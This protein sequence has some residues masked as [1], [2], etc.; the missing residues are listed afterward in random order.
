MRLYD[1]F[2]DKTSFLFL[3]NIITIKI[4][5]VKMTV[6]LLSCRHRKQRKKKIY[7]RLER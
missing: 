4:M 5:T 3:K 1:V 6:F 2:A 7:R